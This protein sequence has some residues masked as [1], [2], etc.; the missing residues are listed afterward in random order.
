MTSKLNIITQYTPEFHKSLVPQAGDQAQFHVNHKMELH[1][2]QYTTN[3]TIHILSLLTQQSLY[4]LP[5]S[6]LFNI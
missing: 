3:R 1:L 5:F 2:T 4:L 6:L